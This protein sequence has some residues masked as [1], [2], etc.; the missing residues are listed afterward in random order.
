MYLNKLGLSGYL[1]KQMNLK[2]CPNYYQFR[3][4]KKI[5][6]NPYQ[7]AILFEL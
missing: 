5:I 3:K 6:E 7:C 1:L 2:H 4:E